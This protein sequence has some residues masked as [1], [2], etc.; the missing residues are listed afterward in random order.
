MPT[1]VNF[2]LWLTVDCV[3][4]VPWTGV[5]FRLQAIYILNERLKWVRNMT[6]VKYGS[7][8]HGNIMIE[9]IHQNFM[10][11]FKYYDQ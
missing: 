7:N 3:A 2:I 1:Y 10:C 9:N 6:F 11:L 4:C 5:G 8:N